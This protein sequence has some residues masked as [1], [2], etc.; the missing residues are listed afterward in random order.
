M[1]DLEVT[2][3][4]SLQQIPLVSAFDCVETGDNIGNLLNY[5]ALYYSCSGCTKAS[6]K[7]TGI[8]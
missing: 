8:G 4:V 3:Q 6:R 2:L 7:E 1:D 5:F